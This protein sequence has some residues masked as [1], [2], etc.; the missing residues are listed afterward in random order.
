MFLDMPRIGILRASASNSKVCNTQIDT[1]CISLLGGEPAQHTAS[2]RIF[3]DLFCQDSGKI[4][5]ARILG[6]SNSFDFS[7]KRT[8]QF[9][10]D[11]AQLRK[12]NQS[13]NELSPLRI[14]NRLFPMLRFEV[15]E[16][17]SFL[18]E[19]D[20]RFAQVKG[21]RLQDLRMTFTQP[22]KL[23]LE[24]WQER[25]ESFSRQSFPCLSV[26]SSSL[27]QSAIPPP[28][29]ASKKLRKLFGLSIG[30]IDSGFD[31]LIHLRLSLITLM[32]T[33]D[34]PMVKQGILFVS[35]CTRHP[36]TC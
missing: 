11:L 14:L 35:S 9:D 1:N 4:L 8:M 30:W 20:K 3:T 13:I 18:K 31:R 19:V 7:I 29:S 32:V 24:C 21:D 27:V 2:R 17:S 23:F 12:I 22:N 10:F 6:D 5:T 26:G 33:Q 36:S 16:L 28:T 25:V 15:R 34:K